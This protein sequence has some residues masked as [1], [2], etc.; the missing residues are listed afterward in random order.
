MLCSL[1]KILSNII[2]PIV[3]DV[4]LH[5]VRSGVPVVE[6]GLI[7]TSVTDVLNEEPQ[8]MLASP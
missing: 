4:R 7:H 8:T 3:C 5:C 1:S 6:D 2:Q